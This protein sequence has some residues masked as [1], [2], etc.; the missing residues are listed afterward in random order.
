MDKHE[1]RATAAQVHAMVSQHF[2]AG[3]RVQIQFDSDGAAGSGGTI[4]TVF[5]SGRCLVDLDCGGFRN[6]PPS[7]LRLDE[8]QDCRR[9]DKSSTGA[10][11]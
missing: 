7:W 11:L 4:R 10:S 2:T 8:S 6:L 3:Q 9:T 5:P 1:T